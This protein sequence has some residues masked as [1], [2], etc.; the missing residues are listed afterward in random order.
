[1]GRIVIPRVRQEARQQ[2][3]RK[4]RT[5]YFANGFG[6]QEMR[7]V[8]Q[9]ADLAVAGGGQIARAVQISN[10]EKEQAEAQAEYDQ[11]LQSE[12]ES[13]QRAAQAEIDDASVSGQVEAFFA[14]Q[15]PPSVRERLPSLSSMSLQSGLVQPRP[16]Q[17]GGALSPGVLAMPGTL[18]PEDRF[19][20][21]EDRFVLDRPSQFRSTVQAGPVIGPDGNVV[22]TNLLADQAAKVYGLTQPELRESMSALISRLESGGDPARME[23]AARLRA[24][25]DSGLLDRD[26]VMRAIMQDQGALAAAQMSGMP[27]LDRALF[28]DQAAKIYGSS[29]QELS[30]RVGRLVGRL[31]ATGDPARIDRARIIRSAVR[32]DGSVDRNRLMQIVAEGTPGV[33]GTGMPVSF[34]PDTSGRDFRQEA[35]EAVGPAPER[36]LF[37]IADILAAAPSARTAEQRAILLQAAADS[38]DIQAANLSDLAKGAYRDRAMQAVMKLFPEEEEPMSELDKLRMESMRLRMESTRESMETENLRQQKL[39]AALD[40]EA[41]KLARQAKRGGGTGKSSELME[42]AAYLIKNYPEWKAGNISTERWRFNTGPFWQSTP[43]SLSIDGQNAGLRGRNL[44]SLESAGK[45]M[46]A[47]ERTAQAGVRIEQAQQRLDDS[48]AKADAAEAR[49]ASRL[50][51]SLQR[52]SADAEARAAK[53]AYASNVLADMDEEDASAIYTAKMQSIADRIGA[54]AQQSDADALVRE[55]QKELER[56]KKAKQEGE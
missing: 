23:R 41:A 22:S 10:R 34:T 30:E 11:R 52:L 16:M 2:L 31:E 46:L 14:Q 25:M 18:P 36:K 21:P 6:P 1:M 42:Q 29:P 53:A 17:R 56:R 38:P 28:E 50:N 7:L 48:R 49:A 37:R 19:V 32:P 20:P 26:A 5:G 4:R 13:R 33:E 55:A 39:Q 15:E 44:K 3:Q 54:P 43:S 8:S 9:L 51:I 35:I 40:K 12:I 24:A 45:N 27:P 47:A